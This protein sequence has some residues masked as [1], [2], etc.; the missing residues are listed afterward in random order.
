MW[1]LTGACLDVGLHFHGLLSFLVEF[2]LKRRRA[3]PKRITTRRGLPTV[4][5]S[6][7]VGPC[8]I[9]SRA[10]LFLGSALGC[11]RA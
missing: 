9:T 4:G 10:F 1:V 7:V 5:R 8:H 11:S 3:G 6:A 2:Y